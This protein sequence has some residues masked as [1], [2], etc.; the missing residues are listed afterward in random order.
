MEVRDRIIIGLIFS[1]CP[2]LRL[3]THIKE[4]IQ[5][6]VEKTI[7]ETG[8]S[9]VPEIV[10]EKPKTSFGDYAVN[11]AFVLAKPLGKRPEEVANQLA[12]KISEN[13]PGEI[14]EVSAVGGYINFFLSQGFLQKELQNIHQN[15]ESFGKTD[16]G[17]GQNVIVEH[18]QP[19]IAKKM[20]VGHLRTTI[21]GDALANIYD[22]LGYK[23]IR[24]NYLGDWGTQFGNLIAAYKKWGKKVEV[25]KN[26]IET[27]LDLYVRFTQEA[28]VNPELESIGR[29][30]FKKLEDGDKE[31]LELWQWFKDES[32]KEFK[33]IY[34]L[35]DI[36]FDSYIGESYYEKELKPLIK[37][38]K[39]KGIAQE[40][41][42]GLIINLDKYDLPP[43][44][45][46]KSDGA[47]LYLTR[48]I[49]SLKHRLSEYHPSKILYVVSNE[50][51]FHFQQLFAIAKILNLD[52]A[53]LE[54][55]KY[56]LVL[57]E[58]KKKFATREG[59]AVFAEDLIN[60][61]IELAREIV[62]TKNP[63][64]PETEKQNIAQT[65]AIGALKY[66]MLKEHRNTD[67]IFDWKRMLDFSGNSAPYLQ[68]TYARLENI[69]VKAGK[70]AE[71]DFAEIKDQKALSLIKQLMEFPETINQCQK[72]NLTNPLA[73][74]LYELANLANNLYESVPILKDENKPRQSTHLVLIQTV[75]EILK[76][77]LA[78]LGIKT[79]ARI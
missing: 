78:L 77:G 52:Q 53:E 27:L 39:E 73:L 50:Q 76:K 30:E 63:A 2:R 48:D 37:E 1:Q 61:I 49:A 23:A 5:Q 7:S 56:G 58:D 67:I 45:I 25:E 11:V 9:P 26:P 60:K 79:L 54:H 72:N 43:A 44:L 21:L 34:D 31:S 6:L 20:H 68:Y 24:W 47:S 22:F 35:L 17:K 16:Q 74:Y 42:G 36:K 12:E 41:E 65:V 40:S 29:E 64:L 13:K 32:L 4:I 10:V 51:S 69:L 70:I 71:A 28:K 55:I 33:K 66:E 57:G 38:V 59:K 3:M 75:A 18:S 15:Q 8:I 14:A 46:Q 62:E 19:N